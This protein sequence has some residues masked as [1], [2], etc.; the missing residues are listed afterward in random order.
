MELNK[1]ILW[2]D[3][4]VNLLKPH[5]IFLENKGYKVTA[6]YSGEEAIEKC[7]KTNFDLVLM[8]EMMPGLD[9][10]STLKIIKEKN[11]LIP[12]IMVTKSEEEWLV[13]EA[14]A[15]K[16]DNYLIKPVNPTQV[17][18]A[19]RKIL[20][21]EKIEKEKNIKQFLSFYQDLQLVDIKNYDFQN[22]IDLNNQLCK[23]SIKLDSI[24][25]TT[26]KEMLIEQS[27]RINRIF[28]E[29]Y[30]S[31]YKK[32]LNE[33][34][35]INPILSKDIFSNNF[36]PVIKNNKNLIVIII[37]CF[38]MDQWF[39]ISGLLSNNFKINEQSHFSIIPSATPF[40]RNAIFSGLMP[41]EIKNQYPDFWSKMFKEGKM[42]QYEDKLF[43]SELDKRGI[44]KSFKYVKISNFDEGQ[45]FYNKINDYK[46]INILSIVV[47]FVDILGHSRSESEVLKELIPN[48]SAY[49]NAIYNW[50]ENSWLYDCFKEFSNWNAEILL[51]SDHGNVKVSKPAAVKAD[52]MTSKGVRYKYG[53][54][55]NVDSKKAYKIGNPEKFLLPKLD[56][57]TEYIIAKDSSYFVYSNKYHKYVNIYKDSF[58]HGG[59]SMDEIIVPLINLKSKNEES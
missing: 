57:N 39:K 34:N 22:W 16:I 9:G 5:I 54:N 43:L 51:T 41:L 19:C 31:N 32:W 38:K 59:I 27:E 18:I 10:L 26:F 14:I 50:F 17:F 1:H 25:E 8:D 15:E 12:I 56:V 58:Q 13:D 45:K 40:A 53:R 36:L 3:D 6:A 48:E 23:W 47:N 33:K 52:N 24:E 28:Q 20:D 37:D 30:L 2:V 49:R 42:N 44:N 21:D 46:N 11:E 55:L 4:E 35:D 7:Q 29:F